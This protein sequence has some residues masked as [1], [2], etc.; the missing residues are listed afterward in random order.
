MEFAQR[1]D[2]SGWEYACRAG[3]NTQYYNGDDPENL[4]KIANIADA[5]FRVT[6]PVPPTRFVPTT[7][8]CLPRPWAVFNPTLLVYT[9]CLAMFWQW[10]GDW[11][12]AGY[13]RYSPADEPNGP[14]TGNHRVI[15]GCSWAAGPSS[16]AVTSRGKYDPAKCDFGLGFRVVMDQ[17]KEEKGT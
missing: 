2:R 11:Y 6:F 16:G 10:C 14:P 4:A 7:D 3:T 5:A 15:R 9:T 1:N 13:Y 12:D 17:M 8:T